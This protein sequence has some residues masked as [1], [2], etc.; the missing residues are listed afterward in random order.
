MYEFTDT[1]GTF[2]TMNLPAEAVQFAGKWLDREIEGFRTLAVEGRELLESEVIDKEVASVDG[3]TYQYRRYLPR[4]IT[5][6]Y[7][8]KANSAGEYRENFNRLNK[9]L[10][11]ERE[12][13]VFY[14]ESDK[15]FIATKTGNSQISGGRNYAVGEIIFYCSDP[16]KYSATQK[17]IQAQPTSFGYMQAQII[18]NGAVAVPIDYE[19]IMNHEN[20][21]IGIASEEGAMEFGKKESVGTAEKS[22][23]TLIAFREAGQIYAARKTGGTF[24][25]PYRNNGGVR[26]RTLWG[27]PVLEIDGDNPGSGDYWHGGGFYVEI[28]PNNYGSTDFRLD[29]R[30]WFQTTDVFFQGSLDI[31]ITAGDR[32]IASVQV[33][34]SSR[35][36]YETYLELYVGRTKVKRIS[37]DAIDT[38]WSCFK[39]GNMYIQRQDGKI[40]FGFDQQVFTFADTSGVSAQ[41]NRVNL[42]FGC[43]S[44]TWQSRQY[45]DLCY[46]SIRSLYFRWDM[47]HMISEIPNRYKEGDVLRIDGGDGKFYVNG[48]PQQMDELVGSKYFLAK[49]GVTDVRISYSAFSRPAPK[50]TLKIREGYM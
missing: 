40:I 27:V 26:V 33:W 18:N 48:V 4:E 8:M 24:V 3:T 22:S 34:K 20:G 30:I 14:D 43:Y 11:P 35:S 31:C 25:S 50:V 37:Y 6:R 19:M 10:S 44:S 21:Y 46:A 29:S 1:T 15:Y 39:K 23:E 42:F 41:A 9:L 28:P 16:F 17:E 36:T 45:W 13:L 32:I 5:V 7:Q 47:A 49:P 12:K 38:S 2:S